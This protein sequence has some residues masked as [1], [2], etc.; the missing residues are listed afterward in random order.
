MKRLNPGRLWLLLL[1]CLCLMAPAL[2]EGAREQQATDRAWL[3][4]TQKAGIA[5]DQL[6]EPSYEKLKPSVFEPTQECELVSF[7]SAISRAV[8]QVYMA[9]SDGSL[10]LMQEVD[11][12]T[13]L[14]A[15]RTLFIAPGLRLTAEG[16]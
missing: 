1:L 10:L 8:F 7:R 5:G 2:S 4:L 16:Q 13:G 12:S 3:Y 11:Q 14:P 15:V 9:A 6:L